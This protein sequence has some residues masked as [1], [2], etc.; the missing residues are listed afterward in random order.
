MV[1]SLLDAIAAR[2]SRNEEDWLVILTADHGGKGRIHGGQSPEERAVF[3]L[4]WEA[5]GGE[6]K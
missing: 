1:E 6:S 3:I 4:A 5:G 2:P